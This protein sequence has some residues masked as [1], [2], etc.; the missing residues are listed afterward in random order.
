MSKSTVSGFEYWSH[1]RRFGLRVSSAEVSGLLRICADSGSI[2]VGGILVGS[3]TIMRDCA[4]VTAISGPPSDSRRGPTWFHRGVVGL[5]QWLDRYW[6]VLRHFYL[7]E[8][9][10]HPSGSSLPS[11]SDVSQMERIAA[12]AVYRCPEPLLLIVGGDPDV[13]WTMG[14]YV[15]PRG[16]QRIRLSAVP[17]PPVC[18]E[19]RLVQ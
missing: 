15:F 3:Y 19:Q 7:G 1:D 9:H 8:W 2:E 5:Q 17:A 11:Q 4:V 18:V 13:G 10:Y 16:E 6:R 14:A 12:S